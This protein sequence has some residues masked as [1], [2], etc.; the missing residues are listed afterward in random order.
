M[1][2]QYLNQH[3]NSEEWVNAPPNKVNYLSL[4][5]SYFIIGSQTTQIKPMQSEINQGPNQDDIILLKSQPTKEQNGTQMGQDVGSHSNKN[6]KKKIKNKKNSN[7]EIFFPSN[8][9][10]DNYEENIKPK[11]INKVELNDLRRLS[12]RTPKK[13]KKAFI[14]NDIK[15][16]KDERA[17]R[18]A[19]FTPNFKDI[20]EL[21][22]KKFSTINMSQADE[23]VREAEYIQIPNNFKTQQGFAFSTVT[24]KLKLDSGLTGLYN[25]GNTCFLN[26][27]VQCLSSVQ[28]LTDFFIGNL[29]KKLLNTTNPMGTGGDVTLRYANL[30]KDIW[31]GKEEK[32]YPAQ[33]LKTLSKHA[34]HL[35][36]GQQQDAQEFLAYILDSLHEDLNRADKLTNMKQKREKELSKKSSKNEDEDSLLDKLLD[37]DP[38]EELQEHQAYESW[39][40]HLLNNRSIIVDLFQGQLKSTLKCLVCNHMSIKFDSFMY[41]T[42]PIPQKMMSDPKLEECVEEFTKEEILDG[43]NKWKC[44]KCDKFQRATKKI[45]IWKLP[46]VLI[47]NLKRFEFNQKKKAK[48]NDLVEFPLKNLDLTPYVSK[49]QR[50]KPIYDLFAV[51]NH[52]GYL[53]GGHYYSYSKHRNNQQWYYFD[54]EVVKKIK[55]EEKVVSKEAYILFYSKMTVDE[56]FRQTLSEPGLWPHIVDPGRTQNY[57]RAGSKQSNPNLC[58]EL[59]EQLKKETDK[60]IQDIDINDPIIKF[61]QETISQHPKV[62][63]CNRNGQIEQLE[64]EQEPQITYQ[65]KQLFGYTSII[66]S[67]IS[68]VPQTQQSI[69]NLQSINRLPPQSTQGSNS[70][71]NRVNQ[72]SNSNK[73][74]QLIMTSGSRQL[75]SQSFSTSPDVKTV[76]LR[77]QD[78]NQNFQNSKTLTHQQ[79]PQNQAT[80]Q[81]NSN[82]NYQN[83]PSPQQQMPQVSDKLKQVVIHNHNNNFYINLY[84]RKDAQY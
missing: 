26:T 63:E 48:I 70:Y 82:L 61:T 68:S 67:K 34:P 80:D 73:V 13:K 32:I 16:G 5:F 35:V 25:M 56:F 39:K 17:K 30:I 36:C 66:K 10:V 23:I 47:I 77:N 40:D 81:S 69:Q 58:D 84:M 19:K 37:T 64:T 53:T 45:D 65:T 62:Y 18:M 38:S 28:P 46:S 3:F 9:E 75:L 15:S 4:T 78:E 14:K 60:L 12:Q 71:G 7:G 59:I 42:I 33:F 51:A 22:Q 31:Q 52:E 20:I 41:L 8:S 72:Q 1:I 44:P 50:E 27:A 55:N 6:Q 57:F 29:H 2:N 83:I 76:N 74:G 49:L 54:D 21:D 24:S 43:Q 79:N 11:M